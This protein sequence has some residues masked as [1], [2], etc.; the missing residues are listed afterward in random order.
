MADPLG[1]VG[2]IAVA[3]QILQLTAKLS[4]DWK[5]APEDAKSFIREMQVLKTVLS[6]TNINII[7]NPDFQNAF[8]GHGSALLAE[9]GDATTTQQTNTSLLVTACKQ[10][11]NELLSDLEKRLS[12]HRFGWERLKGAFMSKKTREAVQDLQRQCQSLNSLLHIDILSLGVQ[13]HNQVAA[14]RR[15]QKDWRI[16]QINKEIL[17]W[18]SPS[19]HGS[20]Q[21]DFLRRRQPGTGQW[22]LDSTEYQQWVAN[23][24]ETLFC[25]G[26]PGAGKT[27]LTSIVVDDLQTRFRDDDRV[28]I[29]YLYC[30]FRRHAE[31]TVEGLL[32]SLLRQLAQGQTSLP[33]CVL[34][35]H[36]NTKG[37]RRPSV[38]D[39]SKALRELSS[40]L[41]RVFVIVDALDECD[42]SR[43]DRARFLDEVF[44]LQKSSQA[45]VFA[46]S[47][48]NIDITERFNEAASLEIRAQEEDVRRYLM[49]RI[50]QLPSCVAKNTGLQQEVTTKIIEAVDGM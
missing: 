12:S 39:L 6:E 46:T 36:N 20:Q 15:E 45:N 30:N 48:F 7:T 50:S 47:R 38:E 17:N 40:S 43:G 19:D 22:L 24:A 18:L 35:L 1:I 29:A 16:E 31:Q 49:G 21:S 23:H 11:L 9:L 2:V 10:Q 44:A 27:V 26:I 34:A 5:D 32:S 3:A 33:G 42:A 41:N 14:A 4:L 25:P 8:E 37:R 13:T 28:G